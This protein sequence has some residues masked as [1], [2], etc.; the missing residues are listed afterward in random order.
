MASSS[1]DFGTTTIG[2]RSPALSSMASALS[3]PGSFLC[4]SYNTSTSLIPQISLFGIESH[5]LLPRHVFIVV[6][7]TQHEV[8]VF[9]VIVHRKLC[10]LAAANRA[11]G[12]H[13][14]AFTF[15]VR[16]RRM[17]FSP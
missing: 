5:H 10:W 15:D 1:D 3:K 16:D 17:R 11:A 12:K 14:S 9:R 8:C 4:F 2:L 7:R 6:F 13:A